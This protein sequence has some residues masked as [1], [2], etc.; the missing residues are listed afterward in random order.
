M[1]LILGIL[2]TFLPAQAMLIETGAQR[3]LTSTSQNLT[4][5]AGPAPFSITVIPQKAKIKTGEP[6]EVEILCRWRPGVKAPVP[7]APQP[8]GD[9]VIMS[10][11]E[12]EPKFNSRTGFWEK[13]ERLKLMTYLDGKVEIPVI[14]THFQLPQQPKT[15]YRSVA[16]FLEVEPKVNRKGELDVSLR[17][18]KSPLWMVSFWQL[19]LGLLAALA[20]LGAIA[21]YSRKAGFL[22]IAKKAEP[23]RP[24]EEIALEKLEALKTS[25]LLET[26][27][28]KAYYIELTDILRHYL[29]GRYSISAPDRTTAELMRELKNILDR[30]DVSGLRDLLERSDM[31][32][33]AKGSPDSKEIDLDWNLVK[34][35]VD[36]TTQAF[37]ESQKLVEKDDN[38][39]EPN[40]YGSI[41]TS[42]GREK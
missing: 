24:P 3:G 2:G 15:E 28:F 26:G 38:N 21:W 16:Q 17:D 14:S 41:F 37:K 9:W 12:N 34:D 36:K 11:Q 25:D 30:K 40:I 23:L 4:N 29:E 31:I 1:L 10:R 6:V 7:M 35:F 32:K 22:S 8:W 33:F 18:I 42:Q 19:A 13:I 20:I 39:H 27:N 5:A